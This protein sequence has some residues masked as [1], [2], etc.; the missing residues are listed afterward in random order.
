[1][2]YENS[3]AHCEKYYQPESEIDRSEQIQY[4]PSY[5]DRIFSHKPSRFLNKHSKEYSVNHEH[6]EK[7]LNR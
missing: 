4:T 5:F 7:I 2:V 6:A 1:M 3:K